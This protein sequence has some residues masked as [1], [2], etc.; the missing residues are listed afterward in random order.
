MLYV[1][2]PSPRKIGELDLVRSDACVSIYLST[3]P[4]TQDIGKSRTSLGQMV[5]DA[6]Q[7][8]EAANLDK[9]RIWALQEHFDTV[10]EDDDFWAHQANSLAILASPDKLLTYR[11][12]NGLVDMVTVADR[13]HL[14]PLLRATTFPNA[15]HVLAVSENHVRLIEVSS[16]L[17]ASEVNVPNLPRD[18]ASA[19]GKA[20]INDSGAGRR[21]QG[22]EGQKIRLA[23]YIRKIDAAL[24]PVLSGS[25]LPVILAAVQP[26]ASLVHSL[27]NVEVL[28]QM[29]EQS[30]D[31]LSPADLARAARPILDAHYEAEI[32]EFHALFAARTSES[33][34]TTDISDAARAST[35]GGIDTLL[36]DIDSV[37]TGTIDE[38]TG[39]LAF[40]PEGGEGSYGVVD[41][42]AGR[43]LRTGARVL[44]VRSQ[45]I[46]GEQALAAILRYPI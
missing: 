29:I 4:L 7:Q 44:A 26:V 24:H 33:R 27:S 11:L 9:R 38:A 20:T 34:T 21:I 8:L 6:V 2:L 16:D 39:A 15:A 14:K 10:L 25:D 5:K 31:N 43:A 17:P 46:P 42:I 35:F 12:P 3:T 18:A 41:E 23:Q 30:P 37:I 19:V 32:A 13:F 45:D 36:V 1:D 22:K 40:L 28:D